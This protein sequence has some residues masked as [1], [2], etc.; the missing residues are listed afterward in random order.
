MNSLST[1]EGNRIPTMAEI[2]AVERKI[3]TEG[4]LVEPPPPE[5]YFVPGLYARGLEIPAGITLT[6]KIHRHQHMAALMRG[7]CIIWS[8]GAKV[9]MT[10]PCLFDSPAGVK[11]VI[12]TLTDCWFVTFHPNPTDETNLDKIEEWVIEPSD[13]LIGLVDQKFLGSAS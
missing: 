11:R 10:G 3:A 6:G 8:G 2:M 5:H 9:T 7:E 4:D 12:K 13:N 1:I